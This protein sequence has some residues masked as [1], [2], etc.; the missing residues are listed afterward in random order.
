MAGAFLSDDRVRTAVTLTPVG[1]TPVVNLLYPHPSHRTCWLGDSASILVDF[2]FGVD[3]II[4]GTPLVSRLRARDSAYRKPC[5]APMT[6]PT[7]RPTSRIVGRREAVPQARGCAPAAQE[8]CAALL[9]D[10][11][12]RPAGI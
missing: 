2:D 5:T 4:E 10:G 1:G 8:K 9:T 7:L 11:A 12:P 6:S 3:T